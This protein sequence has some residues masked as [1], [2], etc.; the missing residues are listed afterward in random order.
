MSSLRLVATVS[1]LLATPSIPGLAAENGFADL[2]LYAG[3]FRT[4]GG[5]EAE[6]GSELALSA[7]GLNG[8]KSGVLTGLY[9]D[10]LGGGKVHGSDLKFGF[11]SDTD[12]EVRTSAI[13]VLV[14][15]R[16]SIGPEFAV[17]TGVRILEIS[18]TERKRS[19]GGS[20][21]RFR[22]SQE[23]FP[24]FSVAASYAATTFKDEVEGDQTYSAGYSTMGVALNYRFSRE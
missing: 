2:G 22:V 24:H 14:G 19:F 6:D 5:I 20:E 13:G 11:R 9:Y 1:T 21:Y 17:G 4:L 7:V 23:I 12:I 15:G 16:F 3:K 10:S 8:A 18:Q